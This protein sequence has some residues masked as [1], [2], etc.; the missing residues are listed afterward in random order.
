MEAVTDQFM[1]GDNV[2]VAP[3][4]EKGA[5]SRQVEIPKGTWSFE[6]RTLVSEGQSMVLTPSEGRPVILELLN[7]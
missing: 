6:G 2:L 4:Y 3:I 1:L 5:T 7:S